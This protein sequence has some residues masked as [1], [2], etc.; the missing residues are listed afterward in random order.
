MSSFFLCVSYVLL[1]L[2]TLFLELPRFSGHLTIQGA[3]HQREGGPYAEGKAFVSTGVQGGG[4]PDGPPGPNHV[5]VADLTQHRTDEGWLYA[6]VVLNAFSPRVVGWSTGERPGA[7]LATDGLSMALRQR[8]P[9]PGLVHHSD[10][11]AQYMSPATGRALQSA[12]MHGSM[13]P[14]GFAYDNAVAE[15][16][17]A[18]LQ[19]EILDRQ[20]WPTR[21]ASNRM[22]V[23]WC[24][25]RRR[26]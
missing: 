11:G 20:A 6:G 13:R 7:A 21:R 4:G 15:S 8:R 5:W 12:D 16:F 1:I 14:L 17:F 23:E 22:Q 9:R 3:L 2:L 19:T 10:H 25:W 18:S 26:G 24:N